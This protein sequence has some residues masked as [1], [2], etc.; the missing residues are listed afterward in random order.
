M[1]S[2]LKPELAVPA[3]FRIVAGVV[4]WF[5]IAWPW[6]STPLH[7]AADLA[8][9]SEAMAA[10]QLFLAADAWLGQDTERRQLLGL[11]AVVIVA[12]GARWAVRYRLNA[13]ANLGVSATWLGLVTL[14]QS[15]C[16][17]WLMLLAIPVT[18]VVAAVSQSVRFG[19][20]YHRLRDRFA[21]GFAHLAG[22]LIDPFA[23]FVTLLV[24]GPS[25][26]GWQWM[27][28][29]PRAEFWR[30]IDVARFSDGAEVQPWER[31]FVMFGPATIADWVRDD[32]Q[33]TRTEI[34]RLLKRHPDL[35]WGLS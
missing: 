13:I 29:N 20:R 26:L 5:G 10:Q 28:I 31:P 4:G 3:L 22:S 27:V 24:R 25:C 17:T 7:V 2:K 14:R 35:E 9:S 15:G 30:R 19:T 16:P 6:S 1:L 21:Y 33:L 18:I 12:V 11:A 34:W 8:R 32:P 23:L